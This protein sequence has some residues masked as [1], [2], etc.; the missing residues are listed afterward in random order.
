MLTWVAVWHRMK[1]KCGKVEE[2]GGENKY[3]YWGILTQH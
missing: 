2:S 1:V 3:V